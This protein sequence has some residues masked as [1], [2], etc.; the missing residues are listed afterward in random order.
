M[1]ITYIMVS[2][3]DLISAGA[4]D[5]FLN[6]GLAT[7]G[8]LIIPV[9]LVFGIIYYILFVFIIEKMNLPTPGRVDEEAG[10]AD[11]IIADK[12]LS[13]LA[14]EYIEKLGGRSNIVEVDSCITRLRLTVNDSSII[15]DEELKALGA[16]G[17]LRPNKRIYR[18]S[19]NKSGTLPKKT[20]FI[21][22]TITEPLSCDK[23]CI[24][25]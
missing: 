9:G 6:M 24:Y 20:T 7:K 19:W 12:G 5:Y 23:F 4:I 10:N 15:K 3:M 17:V 25:L 16:S 11:E 13:G 14:K 21:E 22:D 18:L 8:W 2:V 1:A